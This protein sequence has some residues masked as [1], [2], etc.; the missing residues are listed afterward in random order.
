MSS[1]NHPYLNRLL[2]LD[3]VCQLSG[4]KKTTVYKKIR[5]GQFPKQ[6]QIGAPN[7]RRG[8]A[9]WPLSAVAEWIELQTAGRTNCVEAST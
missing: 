7:A 4:L 5:L 2:R 6:I 1:N 8:T 3:E 9:R